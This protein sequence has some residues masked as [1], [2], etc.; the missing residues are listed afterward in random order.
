MGMNYNGFYQTREEAE[1]DIPVVKKAIG[2]MVWV[3]P[4]MR[5]EERGFTLYNI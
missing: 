2:K 3:K 1:K 5:N 4:I